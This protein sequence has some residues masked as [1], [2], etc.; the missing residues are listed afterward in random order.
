[1]CHSCRGEEGHRWARRRR[2]QALAGA[3]LAH[4]L[5]RVSA[6]ARCA[7]AGGRGPSAA[8]GRRRLGRAT[9]AARVVRSGAAP[10]GGRRRRRLRR[11][12][13]RS[14]HHV[15]PGA[16]WRRRRVLPRRGKCSPRGLAARARPWDAVDAERPHWAAP[17]GRLPGRLQPPAS[18]CPLASPQAP[19][20]RPHPRALSFC[21]SLRPAGGCV[22]PRRGWVLTQEAH[23]VPG[24][25]GVKLC[26]L[27][28]GFLPLPVSPE[29]NS[30][31]NL[32][33]SGD[34]PPLF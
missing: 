13:R 5:S 31:F 34:P 1:M 17:P 6:E 25:R 7:H 33:W 29:S 16:P 23:P 30:H 24:M 32:E 2:S 22:G 21:P 3:G 27:D 19:A 4:D 9:P 14:L 26:E 20:L 18:L 15:L 10:A 12:R 28:I 8:P 11:R